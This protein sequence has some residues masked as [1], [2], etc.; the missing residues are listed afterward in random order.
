MNVLVA[1]AGNRPWHRR[2]RTEV[3]ALA[4][5]DRLGDH[6]LVDDPDRAEI[7]LFV[8][9]HQHPSDWRQRAIRRHP[10][11]RAFPDRSFVF[12][13]RDL[14]RDSLPGVYVSMP[15]AGFD[16]RRHR[17]F[18]YPR[19]LNDVRDLPGDDPD[20]LFS[21]QGRRVGPVRPALLELAHP[22]AVVE[23]TSGYDFFDS[24]GAGLEAARR[25]YRE[26][27]GR[28]KFVLCP[29]GAG[30]S[31]LRIFES[32]ACGRVPVIVSDDWVAPQGVDW[33]ACSV[34]VPER[35]VQ[36]IPAR[37]EELE[38]AWPGL[39]TAARQAY[40]D[41]FA[42]DVWFHRVV[43]HCRDLREHGSLGL[44]R[45]WLDRATWRAGARHW[46]HAVLAGAP[47]SLAGRRGA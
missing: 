36:S 27:M 38:P 22:R 10:F 16:P 21:F 20:L 6:A 3:E 2:M 39:S 43:E 32:L 8:D 25:R 17:A 45:Q 28:S 30:T 15:R 4:R 47:R 23:D 41:W 13:E 42:D 35:D 37:L 5:L 31:S 11:V 7:I 34:R 44:R 29:R 18:A 26:V 24:E 14:P 9:L 1:T 12:D 40:R 19:L 33:E 46:K